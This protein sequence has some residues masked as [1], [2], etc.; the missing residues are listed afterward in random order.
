MSATS[1]FTP[2]QILDAARRA[3]GD[4]NLTYAF[5]FYRHLAEQHPNAPEAQVARDALNRLNAAATPIVAQP[6]LPQVVVGNRLDQP[7]YPPPHLG[8]RIIPI[9]PTAL[10]GRPSHQA[11]AQHNGPPHPSPPR[12]HPHTKPKRHYKLGRT[13]GT[14]LGF[15][16]SIGVIA[17]VT[18][19]IAPMLTTL[20]L[21]KTLPPFLPTISL[22]FGASILITS[23]LLVLL[24]QIARASFD[25]ADAAR[26]AANEDT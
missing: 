13:L 15:S 19:L 18:A 20:G 14:F 24:S 1:Q 17:A 2:Q 6:N 22:A 8:G 10:H 25:A 23:L 4:H 3:E 21:V 5:Q 16:G 11:H 12:P 9:S 26:H 7:T